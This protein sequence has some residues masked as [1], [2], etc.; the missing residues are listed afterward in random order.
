LYNM[1]SHNDCVKRRNSQVQR[2]KGPNRWSRY[3][4]IHNGRISAC[5][6]R[7]C[8]FREFLLAMTNRSSNNAQH[9]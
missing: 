8:S 2:W 5:S 3:R 9:D 1:T 7:R 6:L 4:S